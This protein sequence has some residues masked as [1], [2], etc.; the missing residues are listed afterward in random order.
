[1]RWRK[2]EIVGSWEDVVCEAILT[3]QTCAFVIITEEDDPEAEG[4]R[5]LLLVPPWGEA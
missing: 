2:R 1:M 4:D 5:Y 3:E